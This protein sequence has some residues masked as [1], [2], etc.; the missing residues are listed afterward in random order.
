MEQFSTYIPTQ[1]QF[2]SGSLESLG[3]EKLPGKKALI[4]VS[5][6]GSMRRHGY[7]DRTVALLKKQGID[8]VIFD[9]I[10]PN[11]ILSH[12]ME[13]AALARQEGCDFVLGLGG[14]SSIDSAKS[15][16]VMVNNPGDY[17][18][19]INGGSGKGKPVTEAVLPI[20]AITTTA[21]TGTEADPWTVITNQDKNEK[22]G[23]GTPDTFPT[24][25]IV[26][27]ELM[28]SVPPKLTAY[29]G[30]DAFFHA[31]EGYIANI[32]TPI[33]DLYA[34][35]SVRLIS[36][37]LPRAVA[38]GNDIEARSQVAL[39]NT[40]SGM[41]ESTS[42]C[43]SEHSMEHALSAFK[44]KLPHGAGLIMLS[45]AY[46]THFASVVP[47]RL[48]ELAAAMGEETSAVPEADRPMLMVTALEKLQRACG[49]DELKMSDYGLEKAQIPAYAQNARN[50]MGGLFEMDRAPLS[51][52]EV[53]AIYEKAYR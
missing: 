18:D 2:G 3:R 49:V 34:L 46:F 16:A 12:V 29:Q 41:V 14:G 23:F 33:S 20:V 37:Y 44:P 52:Q 48:A 7:L 17:W 11:P 43:T 39:A 6:G 22:I 38:D 15:I 1:I 10:L 40:L 36:R 32:A 8:S 4:V 51:E 5:A 28:L 9:K 13:G 26:D 42:S 21:G 45:K 25:S 19:Y 30:F 27:P 53:I 31:A 47:Q 24:L 50:T 35:E